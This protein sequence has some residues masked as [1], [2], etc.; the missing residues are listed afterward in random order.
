MTTSSDTSSDIQLPFPFPCLAGIPPHLASAPRGADERGSQPEQQEHNHIFC[1]FWEAVA[2][3]NYPE[4]AAKLFKH[5][6]S[7][8]E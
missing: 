6:A 4:D 1:G 5:P 8:G 3:Y 7:V 2:H